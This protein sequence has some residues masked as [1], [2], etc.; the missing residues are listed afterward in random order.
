MTDIYT[1][2]GAEYL[3]HHTQKSPQYRHIAYTLAY[4]IRHQLATLVISWGDYY[5]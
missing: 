5:E 1:F 2:G 3:R 4:T